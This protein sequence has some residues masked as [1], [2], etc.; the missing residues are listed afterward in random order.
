MRHDGVLTCRET[1]R[2]PDLPYNYRCSTAPDNA[3]A[4][5]RLYVRSQL[6]AELSFNVEQ[7]KESRTWQ[8]L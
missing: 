3:F 8:F 7:Q 2:K 4:L 5:V 1:A 6:K